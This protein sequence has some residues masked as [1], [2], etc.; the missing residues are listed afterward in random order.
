M[1]RPTKFNPERAEAVLK[2]VRNGNSQRTAAALAGV[3]DA[4]IIR[5][6]QSFASFATAYTRAEAEAESRNVA[7][8]QKAAVEHDVVLV[9]ETILPDGSVKRVTKTKRE[10]DWQAA[11]AWLERRRHEDW[12][13][14]ETIKHTG[15]GEDEAVLVENKG[16]VEIKDVRKVMEESNQIM[17]EALEVLKQKASPTP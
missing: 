7:M 2:A 4:T 8:I 10:W 6:R 17:R 16:G 13:K 11:L 5:W 9:E 12:G 1:A 14:R 3:D 15:T